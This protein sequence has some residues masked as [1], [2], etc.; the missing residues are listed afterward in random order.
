MVGVILNL[1]LAFGFAV[2]FADNQFHLFAA[3]ISLISL[4]LMFQFKIDVLWI[5][6]GGGLAG[7]LKI[8]LV[9]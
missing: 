1:A 9:L 7:L 3:I 8:W 4:I 2:I 6:V 5:V